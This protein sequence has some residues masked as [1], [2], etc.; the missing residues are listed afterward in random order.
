MSTVRS[1]RVLSPHMFPSFMMTGI[2]L[3]GALSVAVKTGNCFLNWVNVV[4]S[5]N[6]SFSS[7]YLLISSSVVALQDSTVVES[8]CALAKN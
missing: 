8:C 5:I 1:L 4:L 7:S 2:F 6:L 3:A